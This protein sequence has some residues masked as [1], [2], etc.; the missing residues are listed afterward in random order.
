[1][2]SQDTVFAE[3][4]NSKLPPHEVSRHRL[5]NEAVS[6][7]GAGFETT[8]WAL[9]VQ[10]YFILANPEIHQ[11]LCRELRE[12]IPDP[13][14]I[15][16]WSEL[17]KQ[18]YLSACIE[19]GGFLF[20]PPLFSPLLLS[21][22]VALLTLLAHPFSTRVYQT[23]YHPLTYPI[24]SGLRLSYGIVQ[25]SPR[26]S[27]DQPFH[28]GK[29][30]IPPG[31]PI[32]LDHFH[33]HHSESVFP[34]SYTYKPERW[35]GNPKGPDG[36][37]QLSR[38]MVAFSRGNRMC[39]GMQMA[40]AEMLTTIATLFRRFEMELF[41]TDRTSVDFYQDFVTPQV[42]PGGLGVRVLVN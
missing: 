3:L 28:Y 16:A 7:I 40:Y 2:E 36:V 27:D 14:L 21:R 29:Y 5:Q 32:S 41:E 30:T 15:P 12:A 26:V 20:L 22:T 4:M 17:Q 19:E 10:S 18:P 23:F 9:T 33:Q 1:M 24:H 38:Y 39:L 8:R 11:R 25:R 37:K 35:L 34:D 31:T 6:V 42:R 13:E